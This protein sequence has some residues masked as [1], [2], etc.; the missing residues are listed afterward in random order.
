MKANRPSKRSRHQTG[1]GK[2]VGDG[3]FLKRLT[4]LLGTGLSF[5]PKGRP[6]KR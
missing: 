6:R 3:K 1:V 2:F 4:E 5:R